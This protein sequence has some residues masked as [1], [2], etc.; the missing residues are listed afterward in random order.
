MHG[1]FATAVLWGSWSLHLDTWRIVLSLVL[2]SSVV[3]ELGL[4]LRARGLSSSILQSYALRGIG[5]LSV[6]ILVLEPAH[7]KNV[8]HKRAPKVAVLVDESASLSIRDFSQDPP[9]TFRYERLQELWKKQSP[10]AEM[11]TVGFGEAYRSIQASHLYETAPQAPASRL[12]QA[13]RTLAR[14]SSPLSGALVLS[15]G[16]VA[17]D[18]ESLQALA[19][20][21]NQ[22][23]LPVSMI[24][25]SQKKRRDLA[26]RDPKIPEF[27][28]AQNA[29]EFSVTLTREGVRQGEHRAELWRDGKLLDHRTVYFSAAQ[30]SSEITFRHS[31][32]RTGKFVYSIR[33][34]PVDN[35]ATEANNEVFR[36][37]SVLRD[38][39]RVLHVAGRPDWDVRA[40]RNLLKRNP[41]VELLSYYI[42][43]DE[44]DQMR[45]DPS[46]PMSLIQ[47]P[48]QELFEEQLGSFDIIILQNFDAT[49]RSN[50]NRNFGQFILDG[51]AIAII[52][53][54][55]GLSGGDYSLPPFSSL[56][57]A[58]PRVED[59]RRTPIKARLT[60]AG[61]V[62]P[63]TA[64]MQKLSGPEG[65]DLPTLDTF[66]RSDAQRRK[67]GNVQVLLQTQGDENYPLLAIAEPGKGRLLELLTASSWRWGFA[68]KLSR[69]DGLRPYDRLWQ[70]IIR[71]SLRED[72]SPLSMQSPSRLLA[73]QRSWTVQL[74]TRE[75]DGR[76]EPKVPVQ[77]RVKHKGEVLVEQTL[78][79]D[80]QG[81]VKWTWTPKRNG[82]FE[83]L[84]SRPSPKPGQ[85][86]IEI[87]HPLYVGVSSPD[88]NP[89]NPAPYIPRLRNLIEK[90]GGQ[91]WRGAQIP[92]DPLTALPV[93][94]PSATRRH[95]TGQSQ[96]Q[97]L[98]DHPLVWLALLTLPAEWWLRRRRGQDGRYA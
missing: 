80:E 50:Y 1:L 55:L 34:V 23:D 35:E 85:A 24:D 6:A 70:E 86:A 89:L 43:R 96:P 42:L 56:L 61:Q 57:P 76:L 71:W 90:S 41:N 67:K 33:V 82:R 62:H 7:L 65:L 94:P 64:W 73:P 5:V 60:P 84:V 28:F 66:N 2:L 52:G 14:K 25:I 19:E 46:A 54:D 15:D 12:D 74:R 13:L 4:A 51:G 27:C 77:I 78:T 11:M 44:K 48:H 3:L 39:V 68:P 79:T 75:L 72:P 20:A 59:M 30:S 26:L 18:D 81:Q 31:P 29:Q 17:T 87:G 95:A 37:V 63:I 8:E 69:L 93:R 97:S 38:K 32:Q 98:W 58:I 16:L 10:S 22:I 91:Y 47:F 21:I 49:A 36:S 92:S 45:D 83:V 40:L 88:F 9:G 53:G